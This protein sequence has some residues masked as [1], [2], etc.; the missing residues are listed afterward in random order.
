MRRHFKITVSVI[1]TS[2][3]VMK[4]KA[5]MIGQRIRAVRFAKVVI[6]SKY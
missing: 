2:Y 6:I 1:S 3:R 5:G 4:E